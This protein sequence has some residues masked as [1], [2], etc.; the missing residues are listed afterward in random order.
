MHVLCWDESYYYHKLLHFFWNFNTKYMELVEFIL[1]IVKN[2][3]FPKFLFVWLFVW[4][5]TFHSTFF[6]PYGD[7]TA[8]GEG[9]H[10]LTFTR[11][12]WPLNSDGSLPYMY[13]TYC[14]R[15]P[16]FIPL[17]SRICDTHSYCRAFG[18]EAVTTSLRSVAAGIQTP[19]LPH[20][21]R[22]AC[23]CATVPFLYLS[24]KWDVFWS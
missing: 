24:M 23:D 20:A 4:G 22:N 9:L 6:H 16:P 19:N 1:I 11:H 15:G 2:H 12:W 21:E 10:I 14:D 8:T 7:V 3:C 5:Y 13:H 17:I 18:S